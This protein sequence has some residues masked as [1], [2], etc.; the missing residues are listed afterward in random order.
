MLSAI[1]G[2]AISYHYFV[3]PIFLFNIINNIL[4]E[5]LNLSGFCDII[6]L[7]FLSSLLS[8]QV[9]L[10]LSDSFFI[11]I[12]FRDFR[13]REHWGEAEKGLENLK[14]RFHVGSIPWLEPKSRVS[15]LIDSATQAPPPHIW[16]LNANVP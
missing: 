9:P 5:I 12:Y 16:L 11:F 14:Q 6:L 7:K 4:L 13:E 15:H 3:G 1:Q 10:P 8:F 2:L